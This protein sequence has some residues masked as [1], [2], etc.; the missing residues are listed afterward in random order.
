MPRERPQTSRLVNKITAIEQQSRRKNRRSIFVNG[1]FAF[2]V[3]EEV[4][5]ELGLRVGLEVREEDLGRTLRAESVRKAR[6]DAL[7]LLGYRQR[8][9]S[10]MAKR[11]A[12]KGNPPDI[13][14]EVIAGLKRVGLMDDAVFS[15]QWV[16]NRLA[17]KP[18]GRR[19]LLWELRQ[20]GVPDDLIEE[21]LQE[22]GTDDESEVA[23]DLAR[24]KLKPD[25]DPSA[26]R[27]R[28]A[29]LLRRR[30]FDWQTVSGVLN[31]LFESDQNDSD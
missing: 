8:S 3:H 17:Q 10:E 26:E 14:E 7:M 22:V 1:E 28:L 20:K 13:V 16:R 2:G 31:R 27:N 9:A 24:R 21:A 5:A 12:Q 4:V 18:M 25:S 30:G 19:G 15:R 11:L 23:L 6:E 29:S